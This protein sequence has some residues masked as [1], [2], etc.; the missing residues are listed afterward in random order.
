M[1]IHVVRVT[2]QE[3]IEQSPLPF[4]Q[5]TQPDPTLPIDTRQVIQQGIA[6]VQEQRIRIRRE[7]GLEVSRSAPESIMA[8]APRDE[9]T[10]VGTLPV[11]KT[12]VTPSGKIQYW[13]ILNM[14]AA[15]YKPSSTGKAPDDPQYG[16]TATGKHLHKGIVAVD[17]KIIPLGTALYIP[18]YGMAVAEDTGGAVQGLVIDLGYDDADYQ[19]W[20]GSVDVYLLAPIPPADQIPSLPEG[21]VQ[22]TVK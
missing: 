14:R 19:E 16:I 11:L 15:S 5:T 18:G 1:T 10:A 8:V 4:R 13:R 9:I 20:S 3:E 22:G 2:E 6:G 17:P 12:L 7:D 21:T